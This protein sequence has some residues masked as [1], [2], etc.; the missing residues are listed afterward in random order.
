M[1]AMDGL[2]IKILKAGGITPA[3]ELLRYCEEKGIK[4]MISSMLETKLG[5]YSSLALASTAKISPLIDLDAAY[6]QDGIAFEG[7]YT[8][9]GAKIRILENPIH[10]KNNLKNKK[11]IWLKKNS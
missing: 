7:G 10:I 11:N 2:V 8:Q 4:V 3:M 5:V 1:N 6:M 9:E